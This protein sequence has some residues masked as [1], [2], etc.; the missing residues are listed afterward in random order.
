MLLVGAGIAHWAFE[1]RPL[2]RHLTA[3]ALFIALAA[4]LNFWPDRAFEAAHTPVRPDE[5][6]CRL[7]TRGPFA[8]SRISIWCNHDDACWL[9]RSTRL[10]VPRM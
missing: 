7:L 9:Q 8:Y 3:G 2:L 4:G 1:V 10:A 5:L 6:P